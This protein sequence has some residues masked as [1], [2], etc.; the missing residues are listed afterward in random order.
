MQDGRKAV[1]SIPYISLAFFPSLK[2]NFIAYRSSKISDCIFEILQLWQSSFCR[3]HCNSCCRCSF[4]PEII[5]INVSSNKMYS[6]HILDFQE[7]MTVLNAHSKNIWKLIVCTSYV[8]VCSRVVDDIKA[9]CKI[10]NYSQSF[11][12]ILVSQIC[13]QVNNKINAINFTAYLKRIHVLH[14][15][16]LNHAGYIYMLDTYRR[17]D[18]RRTQDKD[19]WRL[20]YKNIVPLTLL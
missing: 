20:L 19:A 16:L 17:N 6:N 11:P 3:V 15:H 1:G 4:E 8:L 14:C 9:W 2:K 13:L 5:K 12:R 18:K 7:S 10:C